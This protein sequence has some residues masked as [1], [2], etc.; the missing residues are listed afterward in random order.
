[1]LSFAANLIKTCF[2]L[3]TIHASHQTKNCFIFYFI[4]IIF[5][6]SIQATSGGAAYIIKHDAFS[7]RFLEVC[8]A[9]LSYCHLQKITY[10]LQMYSDIHTLIQF[11]IVKVWVI[12]QRPANMHYM[13]IA[14]M[15]KCYWLVFH[16]G[17]SW[18]SH[19]PH[20]L[21]TVLWVCSIMHIPSPCHWAL[22]VQ[23]SLGQTSLQ[24]SVTLHLMDINC[25][26]PDLF[27]ITRPW[28]WCHVCKVVWWPMAHRHSG[29][30][31]L[32]SYSGDQPHCLIMP[33]RLIKYI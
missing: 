4:Q 20:P 10:W 1:M 17:P 23:L 29:K 32:I 24:S 9:F 15:H 26:P 6:F 25:L 28:L 21:A 27:A 13:H 11:A 30:T 12:F 14:Y 33:M 19:H 5:Y 16:A 31:S 7:D 3:Y 22:W 18:I 2:A 8:C